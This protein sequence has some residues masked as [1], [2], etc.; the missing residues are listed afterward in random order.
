MTLVEDNNKFFFTVS[1]EKL[2]GFEEYLK[3]KN[4][5]YDVL[6]WSGYFSMK[7]SKIVLDYGD[8]EDKFCYVASKHFLQKS[9]DEIFVNLIKPGEEIKELPEFKDVFKIVEV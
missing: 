2:K 7:D 4:I 9:K 6:V 1:F 3:S 8:D 5:P